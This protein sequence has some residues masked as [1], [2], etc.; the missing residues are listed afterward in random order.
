MP[1]LG[2][3]GAIIIFLESSVEKCQ[4]TQL[5]LLMQIFIV[6]NNYKHFFN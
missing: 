3:N 2:T 4:F 5:I 6:I 1:S